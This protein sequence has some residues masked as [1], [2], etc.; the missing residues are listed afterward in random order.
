MQANTR[1][2]RLLSKS[3]APL[4]QVKFGQPAREAHT[5]KPYIVLGHKYVH[6]N[7][8]S[9]KNINTEILKPCLSFQLSYWFPQKRD[10]GGLKSKISMTLYVCI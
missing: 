3:A 1:L 6:I 7:F 2:M 4:A 10:D 8:R 5:A 9:N